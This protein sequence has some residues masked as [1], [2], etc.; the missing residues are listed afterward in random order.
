MNQHEIAKLLHLARPEGRV[1]VIL[2]TDAYNEVDD[3]Y[4]IAYTIQSSEKL[5]LVAIN[6]AP[7][8][9]LP[10]FKPV[11][12]EI[13][14]TSPGDGMER[15]YHEIFHVLELMG[16]QE[17]GE[18]VYRGSDCFAESGEDIIDSPAARNIV[19]QAMSMHEGERLYV[20]AIGAITNVAAAIR[21]EPKIMD[22]IVVVWLG[23]H[24]HW[25]KDNAAFNCMQDPLSAKTVMDC[26]VPV[27]LLPAMGVTSH[28]QA[29]GAELRENL[30][31]KNKLCDYLYEKTAEWANGL[32]GTTN[33]AKT[34]WDISTIAWLVG[35]DSWMY[36][37]LIH[38]PIITKD[39]VYGSVD[40][41]RH[42]INEIQYVMRD[43][44]LDDLFKKLS[45]I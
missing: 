18:I 9:A 38:S 42:F 3:Q 33:W 34:L 41:S 22:H 5:D 15:S 36:G 39:K 23:G 40:T 16:R 8:F 30:C 26:G 28:L 14:A 32:R 45:T 19:A 25:W 11:N 2:D 35:D 27:V 37:H 1:K 43:K 12:G 44:I 20:V 31:G 10:F 21:M 24:A 29:G 6:A 7:F 17:L 4:A 13:G